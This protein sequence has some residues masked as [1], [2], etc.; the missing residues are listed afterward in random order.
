MRNQREMKIEGKREK[1]NSLTTSWI[2]EKRKTE[3]RKVDQPENEEDMREE[4]QLNN[5]LN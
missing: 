1:I 4:K 5:I 2:K 3:V